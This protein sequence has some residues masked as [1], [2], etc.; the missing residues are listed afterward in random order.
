M[1]CSSGPGRP[2]AEFKAPDAL[3]P[4]RNRVESLL[5]SLKDI[6]DEFKTQVRFG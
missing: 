6:R 1:T 3:R 4:F 5:G 2:P